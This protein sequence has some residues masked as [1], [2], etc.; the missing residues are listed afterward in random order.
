MTKLPLIGKFKFFTSRKQKES[1][2][3]EL[4][5]IAEKVRSI[6][7]YLSVVSINYKLALNIFLKVGLKFLELVSHKTKNDI[8]N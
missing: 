7:T 2:Q 3:A 6:S 8:C 5:S 4:I 1:L